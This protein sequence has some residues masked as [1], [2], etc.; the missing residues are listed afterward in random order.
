MNISLD[1][2]NFSGKYSAPGAEFVSYRRSN[3]DK[4]DT[5]VRIFVRSGCYEQPLKNN[6]KT[7]KLKVPR[8]IKVKD[9]YGKTVKYDI[10]EALNNE[11]LREQR[12]IENI[13]ERYMW[14][15]AGFFPKYTL[16]DRWDMFKRRLS[17]WLKE[18]DAPDEY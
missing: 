16:Q 17:K 13:R 6:I 1:N 7:K 5:N 10:T 15:T 4:K 11:K 14:Q 2:I 8:Y 12:R 9:I 3:L 18:M